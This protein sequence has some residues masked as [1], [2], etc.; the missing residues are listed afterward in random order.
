MFIGAIKLI[1]IL[2]MFICIFIRALD[3]IFIFIRAIKVIDLGVG[4]CLNH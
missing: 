4:A 1:S 3:V 2:I